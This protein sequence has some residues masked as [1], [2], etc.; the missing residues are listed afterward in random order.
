MVVMKIL[1]QNM[2]KND[3]ICISHFENSLV[4]LIWQKRQKGHK[5]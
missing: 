1:L 4:N 2:T 3:K 5:K